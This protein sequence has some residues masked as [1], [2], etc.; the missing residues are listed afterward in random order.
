MTDILHICG[1]TLLLGFTRYIELDKR[2][3]IAGQVGG[4]QHAIVN[5]FE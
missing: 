5:R 2:Y 4:R 3:W 1:D